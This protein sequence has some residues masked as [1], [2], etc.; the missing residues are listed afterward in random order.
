MQSGIVYLIP[1]NWNTPSQREA[2]KT[3][4]AAETYKA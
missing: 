1:P 4:E 3:Q 2:C